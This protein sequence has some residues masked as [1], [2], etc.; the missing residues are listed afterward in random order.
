MEVGDESEER[1]SL[2]DG[3]MFEESMAEGLDW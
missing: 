1:R 3:V 2:W